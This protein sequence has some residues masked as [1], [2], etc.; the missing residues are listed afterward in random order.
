MKKKEKIIE[1]LSESL[2]YLHKLFNDGE[3]SVFIPPIIPS[4]CRS[5]D[6]KTSEYIRDKRLR[7]YITTWVIPKIENVI[8]ELSNK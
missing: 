8:E 3:T 5:Y 4:E 2:D 7:I 6:I 1:Q